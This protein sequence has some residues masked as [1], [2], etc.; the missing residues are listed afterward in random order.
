L[1]SQTYEQIL[2]EISPESML[3]DIFLEKSL[4]CFKVMLVFLIYPPNLFPYWVN[5][6]WFPPIFCQNLLINTP[7]ISFGRYM[8]LTFFNSRLTCKSICGIYELFSTELKS[9]SPRKGFRVFYTTISSA[10]QI[11]RSKEGYEELGNEMHQ[12][13]Q[14]ICQLVNNW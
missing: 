13:V 1:L 5:L 7:Y 9:L 2:W 3:F 12:T 11:M 14:I 6:Q 4:D 8:C 10:T